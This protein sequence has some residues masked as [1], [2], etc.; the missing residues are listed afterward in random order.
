[1][2]KNYIIIGALT[3][4]VC[5]FYLITNIV[6]PASNKIRIAVIQPMSHPTID[7]IVGTFKDTC[8]KLC[9]D[10]DVS[11]YNVAG[12]RMILQSTIKN[13]MESDIA[14]L[15]TFGTDATTVAVSYAL[16]YE[17][18]KP[19]CFMAAE[20]SETLQKYKYLTGVRSDFEA[21]RYCSAYARLFPERKKVMLVYDP[22]IKA[23]VNE[24]DA[25][26]CISLLRAM[27]LTVE[28]ITIDKPGSI[29]ERMMSSIYKFAPDTI[30]ILMDNTI[31]SGI[32]SLIQ[33]CNEY[34]ILLFAA[35]H[36]SCLKGAGIA[37]GHRE[38]LFGSKAAEQLC[39]LVQH[40]F[41]IIPPMEQVR[42]TSILMSTAHLMQEGII[43]SPELKDAVLN[44]GG[45]V[46]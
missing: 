36:N 14:C 9:P 41:G 27:G 16:E 32:D 4:S 3:I 23:G 38:A 5:S 8:A 44:S 11:Y 39:L 42:E 24:K 28:S 25:R 43:V 22:T 13:L 12:D 19:I 33:L 34:K 40:S 45:K 46:I 1:M 26:A 17:S 2:H 20:P 21:E 29:Y 15:V 31:V 7:E 6:S 30:M 10:V 18:V 35:D 37:F